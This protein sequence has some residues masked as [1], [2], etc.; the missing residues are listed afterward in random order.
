MSSEPKT[1]PS[2]KTL[3]AEA[4][5][6][7]LSGFSVSPFNVVVDRSIIEYTS[8]K[9]GLWGLAKDN[10]LTIFKTPVSFFSGFSF[11]WM[12]FVYSLTYMT[13]NLSEYVNLSPDIPQNI[14]KLI[15]VFLV[16]TTTSLIKDKKY[17][18]KYGQAVRPFP[19][20]SLGLFFIRDLVAMASAFTLPTPVGKELIKYI[21]VSEENGIRIAQVTTPLVLQLFL[22]PVHL[23]ALDLYNRPAVTLF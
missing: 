10:L 4:L 5:A 20:A 1:K 17:A 11:R 14:Q 8:G 12:Y 15:M 16:N 23:F 22:T 9:G 19:K 6:G 13:S 2:R 18:I 21:K 7:A 3:L